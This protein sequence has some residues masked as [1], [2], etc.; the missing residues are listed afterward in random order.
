M[1]MTKEARLHSIGKTVSSTT[2]AGKN[3]TATCEKMK[4]DHSLTPYTKNKLK[5]IKDLTVTQTL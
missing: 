4:L 2:G 5:W 3:W 1:V